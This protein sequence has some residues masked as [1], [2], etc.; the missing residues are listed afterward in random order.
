MS[1]YTDQERLFL[2]R[3]GITPGPWKWKF[4]LHG[5]ILALQDSNRWPISVFNRENW[6][7]KENDRMVI[8]QSPDMFLEIFKI[9]LWVEEIFGSLAKNSKRLK[10]L[11]AAQTKC[12]KWKEL[13]QLWE[14]CKV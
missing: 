10:I 13:C 11:L 3:L 6:P 9:C 8:A 5:D 2:E 14:E 4:N 1:E 7:K 12:E